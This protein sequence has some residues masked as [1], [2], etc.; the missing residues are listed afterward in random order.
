MRLANHY[1]CWA[2]RGS[3]SGREHE[4]LKMPRTSGGYQEQ[5]QQQQ[6]QQYLSQRWASGGVAQSRRPGITLPPMRHGR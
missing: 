5:Q 2:D 1:P 3:E 4:D 6:Q